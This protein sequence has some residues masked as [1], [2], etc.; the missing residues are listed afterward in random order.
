MSE[1]LNDS[2]TTPTHLQVNI[3]TL[4]ALAFGDDTYFHDRVWLGL[5]TLAVGYCRVIPKSLAEEIYAIDAGE[6]IAHI[7]VY[8]TG[9][10]A[11]N[12]PPLSDRI[13]ESYKAT[14]VSPNIYTLWPRQD[15]LESNER[16]RLSKC[17]SVIRREE[18][19]TRDICEFIASAAAKQIVGATE[20]AKTV[21]DGFIAQARL[22]DYSVAKLLD[23]L[24]YLATS[25]GLLDPVSRQPLDLT[26]K[27]RKEF[28]SK[29]S[30]T[31]SLDGNNPGS[32]DSQRVPS[33]EELPLNDQSAGSSTPLYMPTPSQSTLP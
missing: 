10:S 8:K 19:T 25:S 17:A 28:L 23:Y 3:K 14:K 11:N 12:P 16:V 27:H 21:R 26:T 29:D 22:Y 2:P 32:T 33:Q 9:A 13:P 20:F 31:D 4:L 7:E 6:V 5:N 1:P 30:S 18:Q 15:W 24:D